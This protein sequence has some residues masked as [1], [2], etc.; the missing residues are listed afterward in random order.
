MAVVHRILKII[1]ANLLAHGLFLVIGHM[2]ST[3]NP[4][5]HASRT[6]EIQEVGVEKEGWGVKKA[7]FGG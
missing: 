3:E 4:T 7:G 6:V 2:E 5:D 1:N